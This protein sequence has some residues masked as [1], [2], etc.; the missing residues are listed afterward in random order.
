MGL[1]KIRLAVPALQMGQYS[2]EG[3]TGGWAGYKRRYTGVN[4]ITG[5]KIDSY[6]LVGVGVG[7]HS[8]TGVLPGTYVDCVTGNEVTASSGNVSFKVANGGSAGLGVYVLKGLATPAPGKIV[9]PS[10]Y[11]K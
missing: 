3:H 9:Q 4:K 6:V 11:L 7:T 8:W 1:N 2:I 5:S 10:P